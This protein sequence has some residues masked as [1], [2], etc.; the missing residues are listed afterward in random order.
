MLLQPVQIISDECDLMKQ[1]NVCS[2]GVFIATGN[3]WN[4]TFVMESGAQDLSDWCFC[5]AKPY[6]M[7][8][9]YFS[10]IYNKFEVCIKKRIVPDCPT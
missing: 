2:K 6:D 3:G 10:I 1:Y 8:N 5:H 7:A 9:T 4:K